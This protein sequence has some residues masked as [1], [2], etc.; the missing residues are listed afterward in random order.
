MTA[1]SL[2]RTWSADALYGP[3]AQS[4]EL[5][6]FNTDGTG[7]LEILNWGFGSVI[8]FDWTLGPGGQISI[9]GR[10]EYKREMEEGRLMFVGDSDLVYCTKVAS[11]VDERFPFIGLTPVLRLPGF[12]NA[13]LHGFGNDAYGF[14]PAIRP[15]AYD[16]HSCET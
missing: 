14:D 10:K 12:A 6:T 8:T 7:L 15:R 5:L 13:A 2:C 1:Q 11:V 16:F 9:Y 3:G 4:D